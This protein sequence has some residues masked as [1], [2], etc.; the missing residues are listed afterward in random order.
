MF[1]FTSMQIYTVTH[2]MGGKRGR[3]ALNELFNI[4]YKLDAEIK[5]YEDAVVKKRE[6]LGRFILATNDLSLSAD[7]LLTYYKG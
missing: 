5:L 3:P 7:D 4:C 2:R 1:E 6:R